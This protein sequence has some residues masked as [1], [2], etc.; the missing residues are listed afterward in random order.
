MSKNDPTVY[1]MTNAHIRRGLDALAKK[2]S[3]IRR[4]LKQAGYPPERRRPGGFQTLMHIIVSQQLSGKAAATIIGRLHVAT[5]P[6]LTS[7]SF[8]R[9]SDAELRT[10]GL[11]GQ[12]MQ[13]GRLLSEAVKARK[14]RP[15][16]L[17]R[18]ADAQAVETITALKGLGRWSAEMYLMFSLG[19]PD[20]WPAGDLGVQEGIRRIKGLATRPVEKDMDGL[21]EGWHPHRSA[22]SLFCWH[23]L[24]NAPEI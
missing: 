17:A 12:K 3:D 18:M 24:E 21:A 2:D 23:Y 8:L 13:Y 16:A 6:R 9:L 4:A 1:R 11:S 15:A 7:V 10:V 5:R 19:R 20:V 22:L 14:F